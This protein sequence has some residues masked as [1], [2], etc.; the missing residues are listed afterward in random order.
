MIIEIH[1]EGGI[2]WA[3]GETMEE[4]V[5]QL[6]TCCVRQREKHHRPGEPECGATERAEAEVNP[7]ELLFRDFMGAEDSNG[8]D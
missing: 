6:L 1:D 7:W 4:C 2:R 3:R 5:K 8:K